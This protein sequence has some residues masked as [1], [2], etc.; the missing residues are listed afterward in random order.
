MSKTWTITLTF[1]IAPLILE[2][3][4]HGKLLTVGSGDLWNE[5]NLKTQV[6]H[7]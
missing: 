4:K 5:K 3:A 6:I 2:G 7:H 1:K